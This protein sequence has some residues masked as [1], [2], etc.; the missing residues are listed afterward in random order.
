MHCINP[1]SIRSMVFALVMIVAS[2]TAMAAEPAPS[3]P[4]MET[5]T[6][7]TVDVPPQWAL[8][9]RHVLDHLAP[10]AMEF[11]TKYTRPDGSLIWR[12]EW[13]GMDGSDDGYESFYNFPLYYALGGPPEIEAISQEV[14]NGITA[15]FTAYG[16]VYNEFDAY[17][18]WMHHGEAYTNFYFFGLCDPTRPSNLERSLRFANLYTGEPNYDSEKKLIRSPINGSRGPH[19]V[20]TAED[21]VTHRPILADYLLPFEDIP[22]VTSSEDWNDDDKFPFILKAM[23]DR[24]MKG[25]VPLNLIATGVVLNAYMYTGDPKYKQW[26]EQYT[27]AWVDRLHMNNGVLPDNIGLSGEIGEN[28]EGKWWGGYYGWRWPHGLLN[29]IESTTIAASNAYLV[30]GDPKYFELPRSVI[31][32]VTKNGKV[33][34]GHFQVPHRHGDQ[35]WYDYRPMDP[36]YILH[37]YFVSRAEEDLARLNKVFNTSEW[38]T[39]KYHSNKRDSNHPGPWY[40]Y[41]TGHNDAYPM[42][43]LKAAY[44]ATLQRLQMIRDDLSDPDHQDVHHWQQRNPVILEALVQLM[45]GAPN[46]VYH[47]G[48]MHTSVRYF[49]PAKQRS[50]IP[51]DVAA[52]VDRLT[53]NGFR[54]QLVNL[55]PSESRDVILQAGMFGEHNFS[56]IKQVIRYPYEFYTI[57][58]KHVRIHLPPGAVGR[59]EIDLDRYVNQPT[60]AFPWHDNPF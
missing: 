1:R 39:L 48:L 10:A 6:I 18:D 28:M 12:D 27:G 23:N 37:L 4:E 49:D 24:M 43:I 26:I 25:D 47:G 13:P 60:Y 38:T 15:Q 55:H 16:Q 56:R 34:D 11:V 17:Y 32:V 7:A 19:F 2:A 44:R 59:L 29:Q 53:P 51:D 42:K 52:L 20:N 14:W 3:R 31:D 54:V 9:E 57:N 8:Y 35:G 30:T 46:H 36:E 21:W 45:L 22:H 5:I 50:G 41:V 40:A 33:I 58:S